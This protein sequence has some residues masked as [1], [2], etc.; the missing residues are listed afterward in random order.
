M[1]QENVKNMTTEE[2]K[3]AL[4]ERTK[5]ERAQKAKEKATYERDRDLNISVMV[6]VAADIY[7]DLIVFKEEAQTMMNKQYDILANYGGIRKGS[8]GG[9]SLIN[10]EGTL[11]IVRRR[12]TQPVWDERSQ[13]AV[14][15]IEE[16]LGDKIKNEAE[17]S[18]RY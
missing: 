13:K 3:E 6:N 7:Q 10:K 8:K 1:E 11:K 17:S 15:L 5:N 4:A 14:A 16:F 18:T 12:D 2:L 9:F